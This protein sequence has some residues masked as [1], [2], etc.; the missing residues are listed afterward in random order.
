[1]SVETVRIQDCWE[2]I[3]P[4]IDSIL[5][6]LPWMDFRKEDIY[7]SCA[8]GTAAVFIDNEEPLGD[9]FFIARID[10]NN[11][12]GEKTLFLWIAH[13]KADGTAARFHDVI[14]DI[15]QNS[16]CTAVEFVTPTESVMEHGNLYGFNKVMYRCRRDITPVETPNA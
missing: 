13:S 1:M 2:S 16:G 5:G 3:S 7:A 9:S 15:A 14:A 6:N 8:N 10:E 11:S 4:E 12:T